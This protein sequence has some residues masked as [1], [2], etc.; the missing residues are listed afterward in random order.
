MLPRAEARV[1]GVWVAA[2]LQ[3][4]QSVRFCTNSDEAANARNA[5]MSCSAKHGGGFVSH[6][7]RNGNGSEGNKSLPNNCI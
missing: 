4:T 1:Q 5:V 2:I 7:T 6:F 3:I